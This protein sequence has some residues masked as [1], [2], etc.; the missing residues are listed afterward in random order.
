M[1]ATPELELFCNLSVELAQP[2][3]MGPGRG[4]NRRIIPIV[5]GT[6]SGPFVS[7]RILNLGADW[8]TV[9]SDGVAYLDTRYGIE[10]DAGEI[11]EIVNAGYRHG[12]PEVLERLARGD[13][14]D[15]DEYYM[16]TTATLETASERL[17]WINRTVFVGVGARHASAV[18]M[19]LYAVR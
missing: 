12:P 1:S 3:E 5:G 19:R 15:P 6:A 2:V 13:D 18:T 8:Q 14:V 11:I 4:G 9:Y 7:G 10:S 16:R 17:S